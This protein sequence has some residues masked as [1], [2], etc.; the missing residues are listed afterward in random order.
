MGEPWSNMFRNQFVEGAKIITAG[1]PRSDSNIDLNFPSFAKTTREQIK[2]L[3]ANEPDIQAITTSSTAKTMGVTIN[4]QVESKN[5]TFNK[6]AEAL[7][8][9]FTNFEF[10][11]GR[12]ISACELSGQHDF[13]SSADIIDRFIQLNG[14]ILIR[15]HYN[16]MWAIPY[17]F[18]MIGVDMIDTS[19]TSLII[20]TDIRTETTLNG[21]IRDKNGVITHIYIY[22]NETKTQ[23]S[24]VPYES[25]TYYS[26]V[27]LNIDQQTAVSRLTSILSRL[28]MTTQYGI[29]ELE[30]AIEEAKAG[31][32][33]QSETYG[34]F[35]KIVS[36]ELNASSM[37]TGVGKIKNAQD[38][39][40]PI[41]QGMSNVG[42]KARGLTPIPK[43]D[44]IAFNTGKRNGIYKEMNQNSDTKIAASQG[45]SDIG[46]YSKAADANYSSIKFTLETDQ[47]TADRKF[48]SI[49]KKIFFSIFA[50]LIQ[51]GIQTG[52]I[53]DRLAYWKNP[54]EFNKFRY[55]RQNKIDTEPAKNALANQTNID[56]GLK[57]K[58]QIV[59]EA[60]GRKYE[61]FLS[62]KF[63][64][65]MMEIDYEV[66]KELARKEAY[67]K[68]GIETPE[69]TIKKE[70]EIAVQDKKEK[71]QKL[72]LE[73]EKIEQLNI[74]Q[75][76]AQ[77]QEL[78]TLLEA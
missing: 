41:L 45:M 64:Q 72:F 61:E 14:G 18:E 34:E 65:E 22:T 71:Q 44:E 35:M 5:A 67:K 39:L 30:A 40:T 15:H 59:E 38:L 21:I 51:V 66:K 55:L 4:I 7:I 33:I 31:H 11:N 28:D 6:Q 52:R 43:G 78:R 16:T 8:E 17:K 47:R 53:N 76:N 63:E 74:E 23:S 68:A 70:Q 77:L 75:A 69:E 60:S 26:E 56:L 20:T 46:V 73:I 25:L 36:A 57:T 10:R 2:W 27:W 13:D 62:R 3:N 1:K 50:R 29:A 48:N 49:S 37:G 12:E 24:P 54:N 42:I 32:Y 9:E 19:K 58:G